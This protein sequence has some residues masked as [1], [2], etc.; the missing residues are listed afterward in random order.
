MKLKKFKSFVNQFTVTFTIRP[1]FIAV[2]VPTTLTAATCQ[3]NGVY[4]SFYT[5]IL[6]RYY[7]YL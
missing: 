4:Q 5:G 2:C 7:S 1:H 3:V 6:K